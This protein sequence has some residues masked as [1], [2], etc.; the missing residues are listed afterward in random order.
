M[1]PT[2]FLRHFNGLNFRRI[3][4]CTI[5]AALMGILVSCGFQTYTS[6]DDK[7]STVSG[8]RLHSEPL[9]STLR[10]TNEFGE[11]L[12]GARV[13]IGQREN[14][15]FPRNLLVTDENG[16]I[17]IPSAWTD[18]QPLT[19][20]APG[21]V[22][23][24]YYGRTPQSATFQVKRKQG[25][26]RYELKGQTTGFGSLPRDGIVD[27]GVVF[28]A[29]THLEASTLQISHLISPEMDRISV[30][31]QSADIPSNFTIPKQRE[32]YI[33]P[34]T[35]EK[36]QYRTYVATPG[37][38]KIASVHARFPFRDVIDDFRNGKSFF[39][40]INKI[41]FREL[42][43]KDIELTQPSESMNLPIN[44]IPLKPAVSLTAPDFHSSYAMLGVS[45]MEQDGMYVITDVKRFQPNEKRNLMA[46]TTRA[47]GIVVSILARDDSADF[48]ATGADMEEMTAVTT[49][50]NQSQAIEFLPIVGRPE[51]RDRTLV[52]TPP[53]ATQNIEPAVTYASLVKV[54]VISN[55]DMKLEKKTL[56]WELYADEWVSNLELPEM[57]PVG[58][59][60][61]VSAEGKMR[62]QILFG[63]H[64][65]GSNQ[66]SVGRDALEK[67]S[68]VTRN[69]VDL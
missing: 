48:T 30:I 3:G 69:A 9:A 35:L 52:L 29:L 18:A 38:H 27:I 17:T 45:M 25:I 24:T 56:Q 51:L 14:V 1:T 36:S 10:I 59:A 8:S 41:E 39:D 58:M 47:P 37:T 7:V 61:E 4:A 44:E 22:I 2:H 6:F 42:S 32:T 68:H 13:L 46:A 49:K 33:I 60:G 43:V 34:I 21:H 12:P 11:P 57:P 16:H 62:W 31:G 53:F 64:E 55:R 19:I 40:V 23:A 28:P 65:A 5:S 50:A 63:G 66:R 20:D 26:Q 67:V 15:P 54:E